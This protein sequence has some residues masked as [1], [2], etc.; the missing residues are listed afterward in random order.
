MKTTKLKIN[1]PCPACEGQL[2]PTALGC[3]QCSTE[4]KG[5]IRVNPLMQLDDDMMH[6]LMVFIHC[7]GKISDMEKALGISYPTVKTKLSKLQE[8]VASSP[9]GTEEKQADLNIMNVLKEMESG[10]VDYSSAL[11]KIK[12]LKN[13]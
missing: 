4:I 13:K 1:T 8:L 10:N 12:E 6:F 3:S 7:G 5:P 11:S 9:V 2:Y